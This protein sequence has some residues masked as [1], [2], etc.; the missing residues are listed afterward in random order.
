MKK[1]ESKNT[2]VS[3]QTLIPWLL[4][5]IPAPTFEKVRLILGLMQVTPWDPPPNEHPSSEH[6]EEMLRAAHDQCGKSRARARYGT[7]GI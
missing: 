4:E 7:D 3:S 1:Y 2:P 5:A 6:L